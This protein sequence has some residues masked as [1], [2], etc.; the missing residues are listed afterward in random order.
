MA[1]LKLFEYQH[2]NIRTVT[3]N[4]QVWFMAKDVCEVLDIVNVSDAVSRV[5]ENS[6]C[7]IGVTDS[8]SN[9]ERPTPFINEAGVYKLAFRSN[10]PE[11]EKFTDWLAGE[12]IPQIRRTG[13]FVLHPQ[14][15]LPLAEH[16]KTDTQ[17]TMSKAVN[18]HNFELGGKRQT[19]SY[20]VES[21]VAHTGKKPNELIRDAKAKNLPSKFRT[22]GKQV[23]R[24]EAPEIASCMSLADNLVNE[25][26]EPQKVFA[27]TKKAQEV[28]KGML[29][30]GA[31]PDELRQLDEKK[32]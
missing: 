7:T 29:E 17:I 27:V 21:C 25:G 18:A 16:T 4:G 14:G 5:A 15:I 31:T 12:V 10:K 28:F 1:D 6:K 13:K 19:I 11:A 26:H 30:L 24:H 9:R 23:I 22:S 3:L 8:N 20:N 2:K 32:K